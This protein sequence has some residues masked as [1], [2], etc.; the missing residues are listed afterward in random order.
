MGNIKNANFAENNTMSI[1]QC[2]TLLCSDLGL[3]IIL[4]EKRYTYNIV[5][6]TETET[7]I[8]RYPE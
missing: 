4:T 5:K 1:T 2:I 3:Y 7:S 6:I 8:S